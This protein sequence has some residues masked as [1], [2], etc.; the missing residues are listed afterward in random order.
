MKRILLPFDFSPQSRRALGL[1]LCGV[2]FGPEV[3]I[4]AVHV[5]DERLYRRQLPG[6]PLPSA[7]AMKSYFKSEVARASTSERKVEED[8][9][10]TVVKG[11]P[12]HE[13][14]AR[15][16]GCGGIVMGGQGHGG[17]A[18]TFLGTTA[19]RVVR[20]SPV[21]VYVVKKAGSASLPV[22]LMCAAE[23]DDSSRL[24]L[25]AA[26]AMA[27]ASTRAS[28]TL[29]RALVLGPLF[30]AEPGAPT[31]ASPAV[32]DEERDRLISF[33][34]DTLR[35]TIAD[36]HVVHFSEG[37]IASDIAQQAAIDRIDTLV[38]GAHNDKLQ[39]RLLGSVSEGIV[40]RAACDV[41]VVRD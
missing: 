12:A 31:Y 25:R 40:Q 1:A 4:D 5:I 15:V 8:P 3:L 2:P 35:E 11:R 27:R 21:S 38:V 24:A 30:V 16:G 6:R 17:V 7:E 33:E 10:L 39:K 18:E 41:Y 32:I 14:L 36:R 22:R 23:E 29:M 19:M 9:T 13:L 20:E 34:L 37:G 28:L 26:A